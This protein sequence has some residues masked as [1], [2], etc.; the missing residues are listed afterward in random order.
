MF[1][2]RNIRY[3]SIINGVIEL[4]SENIRRYKIGKNPLDGK[5][6]Q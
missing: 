2:F 3:S 6:N 5:K 4:K 1:Y